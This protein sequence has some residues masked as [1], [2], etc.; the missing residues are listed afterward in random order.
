MENLYNEVC[1]IYTSCHCRQHRM[2]EISRLYQRLGS[3]VVILDNILYER[4]GLSC[5]ELIE[6]LRKGEEMI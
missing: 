1:S 5:P 3:S 2:Y 6:M 4:Q